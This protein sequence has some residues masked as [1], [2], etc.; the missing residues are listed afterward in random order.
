[1]KKKSSF[2]VALLLLS[3]VLFS[4]KKEEAEELKGCEPLG[5]TLSSMG[6]SGNTFD[7]NNLS[8]IPGVEDVMIKVASRENGVSTVSYS[9]TVTDPVILK[10]L[11]AMPDVKV[12][13]NKL[14]VSRQYRITSKGF[15]SVYKEGNLTIIDYDAK[16]NDRYSLKR[17]GKT[18]VRE[19]KKVSTE[20]DYSWGGMLIKTIHVEETGRNL[21]G[22]QKIEFV[23]NHRWGFVGL[24]LHFE[25]G[26]KQTVGVSSDE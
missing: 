12:D 3:I 24:I 8:S 23:G 10:L 17:D 15:Q 26:S 2:I 11:K 5:G 14:S 16:V 1:M 25:D 13:G 20:N 9:G 6:D 18:L 19:V 7:I 21:P 22:V 4:C